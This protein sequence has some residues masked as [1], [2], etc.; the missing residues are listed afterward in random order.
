[1]NREEKLAISK[2]WA[3]LKYRQ[4]YSILLAK[5]NIERRMAKK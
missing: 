3:D 2:E 5:Q 1:M 4:E